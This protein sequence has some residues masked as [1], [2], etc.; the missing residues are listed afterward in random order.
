LTLQVTLARIAAA[1]L[2]VVAGLS[3]RPAAGLLLFMLV[4]TVTELGHRTLADPR[5]V[6]LPVAFFIMVVTPVAM[7]SSEVDIP[8]RLGGDVSDSSF[9]ISLSLAA[10]SFT[11]VSLFSLRRLGTMPTGRLRESTGSRVITIRAAGLAFLGLVAIYR[12]YFIARF[13]FFGSSNVS[14]V[15]K[16]ESLSGSLLSA[17]LILLGVSLYLERR[18]MRVP[19][20]AAVA[21]MIVLHALTGSRSEI[22]VIVITPLLFH[23]YGRVRTFNLRQ[24]AVIG[25]L[26]ILLPVALV[27]IRTGGSITG[28]FSSADS[29]LQ[30]ALEPTASSTLVWVEGHAR[31]EEGGI[32]YDGSTYYRPLPHL[33]PGPVADL[34]FDSGE[35]GSGALELPGLLG[36][37]GRSGL[38]FSMPLEWYMNFGHAGDVFFGGLYG[39]LLTAAYRAFRDP[40]SILGLGVYAFVVGRLPLLLRSDAFQLTSGL[41]TL[42]ILLLA[43]RLFS[44]PLIR[45]A[46][47]SPSAPIGRQATA[48][49]SLTTSGN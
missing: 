45:D 42:V 41:I 11:L 47:V 35:I 25:A 40:K 44:G 10:T 21:M 8:T 9:L 33:I 16:L 3:D 30:I 39:L 31:L 36:Y 13:G 7:L 2:A 34:A 19:E 15:Q 37:T 38:G 26:L 1:A 20:M 22:S 18:W 32:R 48:H 43:V 6:V 23:F 12:V 28:R 24:L 17:G 14:Q 27:S 29:A 5:I 46:S 4:W 49:D